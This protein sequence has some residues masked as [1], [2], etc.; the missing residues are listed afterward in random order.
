MTERSARYQK[1]S[2]S[3]KG[4]RLGIP[5]ANKKPRIE[6]STECIVC[7][8]LFCQV[9]PEGAKKIRK[10]CSLECRHETRRIQGRN[11]AKV[12]AESRRSKNEIY[13]AEL[14]KLKFEKVLTNEQMFLGWDADVILQSEKVAVLWNGKWHFEK[15]AANHSV[16]QVQNRDRLKIKAIR[17]C[18]FKEYV[19]ED[20]GSFDPIFVQEKF[21]ELVN[22]L[23]RGPHKAE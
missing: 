17:D 21:G 8:L 11:S 3:L 19:I 4:R 12:Q 6:I 2:A 23:S 22:W 15:L 16:K 9:V 13:F 5:P 18:G 14:C 1:V 7:G 10:T 20:L